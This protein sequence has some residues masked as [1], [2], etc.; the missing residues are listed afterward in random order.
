MRTAALCSLL[1]ATSAQAQVFDLVLPARFALQPAAPSAEGELLVETNAVR[2]EHGVRRA[3]LDGSFQ[4]ARVLEPGRHYLV[5]DAQGG[6]HR[7]YVSSRPGD[8]SRV[9]LARLGS[10][11]AVRPAAEL[12]GRFSNRAVRIDGLEAAAV[13]GALELL[14]DGRYRLGSITGRWSWQQG[15]LALH[16]ALAHWG[17][18]AVSADGAVVTFAFRRARWRYAL[19]FDRSGPLP[20]AQPAPASE[21][22]GTA[23]LRAA[24]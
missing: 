24:R 13:F 18:G 5:R 7:L 15:R 2:A 12:A 6:L 1:A 9:E 14:S 10:A 21:A 22:S 16:G 23:A 11:R 17:E 4:P 8:V 20:G 19:T 3:D